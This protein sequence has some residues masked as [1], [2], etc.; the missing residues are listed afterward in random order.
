[1]QAGVEPLRGVRRRH[2]HGEHVDRARRRRPVRPPPNRSSRLS[3]PNRS[4]RRRAARIPVWTEHSPV[5]RSFSGS[6][7]KRLFIAGRA[8]QPRGNGLLLDLL[9]PCRQPGLAEVLLRQHVGRNL[10]PE[11]R[12]LYI[13]GTKNHRSVGI[14]NFARG[15]PEADVGVRG[16]SRLGEAP[17]DPHFWFPLVGSWKCEKRAATRP[18]RSHPGWFL[19]H[20]VHAGPEPLPTGFIAAHRLQSPEADKAFLRRRRG[21]EALTPTPFRRA[22]SGLRTT[23]AEHFQAKRLAAVRQVLVCVTSGTSRYGAKL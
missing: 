3:S 1:M 4:T 15:E 22:S 9:E 5:V 23:R 11:A 18:P 12:D 17:L 13:V 7:C 21:G 14:A 6:S 16:L 20:L 19:W 2:L 10:R 8:P